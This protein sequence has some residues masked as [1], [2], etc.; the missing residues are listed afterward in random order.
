MDFIE[1]LFWAGSILLGASYFLP[2]VVLLCFKAGRYGWLKGESL[3]KNEL[4]KTK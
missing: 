3:F 4:E 1:K 2:W